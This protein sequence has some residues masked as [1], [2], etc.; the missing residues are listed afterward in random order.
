M[1]G[2]YRQWVAEG[3]PAKQGASDYSASPADVIGERVALL[4]DS[5]TSSLCAL[6]I[7][8]PCLMNDR[9]WTVPSVLPSGEDTVVSVL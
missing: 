9:Q 3:L 7:F 8:R 6:Y 4:A 1:Q 5:T 2:G